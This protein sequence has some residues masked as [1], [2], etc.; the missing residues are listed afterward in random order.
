M[1]KA[2]HFL[3]LAL[4]FSGQLFAHSS[5][6]LKVLDAGTKQPVLGAVAQILST[7]KSALADAA[8][9][10]EFKGLEGGTYAVKLSL[11][12]YKPLVDSFSI[13]DN[14][15]L[16]WTLYLQEDALKFSEIIVTNEKELGLNTIGTLDIKLRPHLTTQDLLRL[17]PG[18]FIAQHAG[19]G[20]AEQIFL[21][22]FD[23]DHGT[24]VAISVDGMPVNMVSHA[25]GQGYADLHFV[26]PETVE[27]IDFAK[28]P[29]D[30]K[31]GNLNTAGSV[32]FQTKAILPRNMAKVEFGS[33]NTYRGVTMVN[34]LHN[35]DTLEK[36]HNAYVAAEYFYT[37]SFFQIPQDFNRVNLFGKYTGRI[38]DNTNVS[39]TVSSFTSKWDASGQIPDRAVN[40]GRISWFG[41]IDPSEGGKTSRQNVNVALI[42]RLSNDALFQSNLYYVRYKYNLYSNFTFFNSDSINGDGIVQY[43]DRHIFGYNGS[44]S[45]EYFLGNVRFKTTAGVGVRD[46][47]VGLIGLGAQRNRSFLSDVKKGDLHETNLSAYLDGT[48]VFSPRWSLN[49]GL[50]YDHFQFAYRNHLVDT[51]NDKQTNAKG[52]LNPKFNLRYSPLSNLQ[53]YVSAGSGFHSND[54]RVAVANTGVIL[55]RAW[56]TDVG[57]NA[58]LL[59]RVFVNTAVWGMDLESELVYVG[60]EG[61]FEPSGRTRRIGLD[62]S[63]RVQILDWLFLDCDVNWAKP[64]FLDEPD[65]AHYVPLAPPFTSIA[66]LNVRSRKGFTG[67]LRYRYLGDRPAVEDN[68]IIAKGY[69]IADV[70]FGYQ[71]RD[72]FQIGFM[73]ENLLDQKWKEAQFATESK[74]REETEAVEEIHFTPGTPFNLR[75]NFVLYF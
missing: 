74:L 69:F 66:G 14:Q 22:G 55:A 17:V 23:V 15:I 12:G 58:K 7:N 33:F 44:Y 9:Y 48:I 5:I 65:S 51:L 61:V 63:A 47:Q 8:G 56:S 62:V 25:H 20:K 39:L 54:T 38:S 59:D 36:K 45:K 27:K 41:T 21:R 28:G 40:S 42:K 1:R 46:D 34:L 43:D 32:K 10:C 75:G 30:A 57:F 72:K 29:Y 24:D 50:R 3:L 18:L 16:S 19:G 67:S 11:L 13:E 35:V 70:V 37:N 6:K 60:D 73:A 52:I 4:A 71:Y 53:L 49:L 2:L 64:R 68:S 26:I 31:T